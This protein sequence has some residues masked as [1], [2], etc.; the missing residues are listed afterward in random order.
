MIDLVLSLINS[1]N[2]SGFDVK[3]SSNELI[4]QSFILKYY[5]DDNFGS[6]IDRNTYGDFGSFLLKYLP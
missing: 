4:V 3:N 6:N 1:L 5:L 2:L